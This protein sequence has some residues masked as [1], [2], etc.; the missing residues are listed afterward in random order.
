M[1]FVESGPDPDALI[2]M[3]TFIP[4]RLRLSLLDAPPE[5]APQLANSLKAAFPRRVQF[6]GANEDGVYVIE[7]KKVGFSVSE[8]ERNC[9]LAC[10][11]QFLKSAGFKLDGSVPLGRRGPLGFGVRRETWIFRG[12]IPKRPES[13]QK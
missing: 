7:V 8:T 10:M 12:T 5:I 6:F 3:T 4:S 9:F 11:L 13:R 2:F 1:V